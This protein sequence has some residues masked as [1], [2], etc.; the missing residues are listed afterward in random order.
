MAAHRLRAGALAAAACL[1]LPGA[2]A[3]PGALPVPLPAAGPGP[4]GRIALDGPWTVRDDSAARGERLGWPRGGFAGD[5]VAV[6]FSPNAQRVSGPR[7]ERAFQG[8][9]TWYRTTFVAPLPGAYSLGFGSVN[10]RADVWV[11]GR[12]L[13][14]HVGVYLPFE[15]RFSATARPHVLVVRSDYRDP[16]KLKREA[17]HRTWFNFGGINRQ[18]TLRRLA[19]S[20]LS[21]PTVRT[22]LTADGAAEVDVSVHVQ[23]RTGATRTIGV[24]G[25]LAH[26]AQAVAL[27]LPPVTVAAGGTGVARVR[28]R[29]PD[30]A[31][32]APDHPD[33]YDIGLAVPGESAW[34]GRTG[35][36]ELTWS[37]GRLL[38]NGRRVVLHGAS[39]QE[40]ARGR[41]D[42][43]TPADMDTLVDEL[44]AI[45]ANA[46]R[47]Q[48]PLSPALLDR[49]DAAGIM[50][51]QGVGPV[52][53]PGAWTSRTP[54]LRRQSSERVRESV[55]QLQ[56]HPS[57]ITWNLAN[58]VA[59]DGHPGGQAEF[60]DR[61]AHELHVRDP[62]RPVAVD[63]WGVHAPKTDR[64]L[65]YRNVDMIGATNYV[66]W[67]EEPRA[68]RPTVARLVRE[69]VR[70][71]ERAFGDK[72]LVISEF[73]A[74]ASARNPDR[75]PGGFGFQTRL[76]ATHIRAYRADA[77]LSGMLIWVLRDFAV[78]P[79][80]NGGSI[81][82]ILPGIDILRGVN[83]KGLFGYDGRPKPAVGAVR[84]AFGRTPNYR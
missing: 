7:S 32:W 13:G 4:I 38:L 41:G 11:D 58:E 68:S 19:D 36:R 59:G 35:L 71:F 39:L 12:P 10:H 27:N 14:T 70:R 84:G 15:K 61:M 6:P 20:D 33:L 56:L 17:W 77:R 28:V 81:R 53:A 23:N 47:A 64:T 30:P 34:R 22:R 29:V 5:T 55:S 69:R 66:G 74:E 76:L 63:V 16:A 44:K 2:Q 25:A 21:A 50:V 60:I 31:L 75:S 37:G 72:V 49:L 83:Q 65:L 24:R 45:G 54:A 42:A 46:T 79:D 18:V 62:S 57:I 8:S 82:E 26:A 43:L 78:T 51:W 48:H 52:D 67:Y 40:D 1:L 73:G 80:F 9:V 3:A